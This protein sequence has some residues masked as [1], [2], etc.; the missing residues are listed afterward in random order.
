[1]GSCIF[2]DARVKRP[3]PR[4]V[5][6]GKA[7]KRARAEKK[8]VP[9]ALINAR[10]LNKRTNVISHHLIT[11]NIGLLA[12]TETWLNSDSGD[13]DLLNVCPAGYS[14]VHSSKLTK[15]G[16]GL[17]LFHR[18]SIRAEVV[19][20]RFFRNSFEHMVVLLRLNSIC[21]RLVILIVVSGGKLLIVG[22][23]NIHTDVGANPTAIK[24]QS[25]LH[26]SGLSQHVH[27]PT[28]LDGHSLELV[29]SR[30]SDNVVT[31]CSVS[32]LICDHFAVH[33][34]VKACGIPRPRKKI[35]Y[36]ELH[37][38]NE[39][40]F[41]SKMLAL[42]LFTASAPDISDLLIQY[43]DGLSSLLDAYAPVRTKMVTVRP[44]NPWLTQEVMDKRRNAR[45]RER[46]WRDRKKKGTSL[47]SDRYLVRHCNKE[48]R[49]VLDS[50][51]AAHLNQE[52]NKALG[53]KSLF[54][55]V[56]SFL[57]KKPGL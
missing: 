35:T 3:T 36:R 30:K 26:L 2:R 41:L 50:V 19:A 48:K 51:K 20:T 15:R 53:K 45:A 12:V 29:I 8:F 16:G 43:N 56:D 21:I 42:P 52:I 31:D 38:I 40:N 13:G 4:G 27:G 28:H 54:K 39:E 57:I 32:Y 25:I 11:Q 47:E 22:D 1:M 18:D 14:A 55:V 34:F 49:R 10:S 46:W 9:F 17:A 6:S 44:S 5:R 33:T 24:F 37:N 23:F 7:A